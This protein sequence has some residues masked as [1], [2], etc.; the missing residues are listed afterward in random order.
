LPQKSVE[1][2]FFNK[3]LTFCLHNLGQEIDPP[4]LLGMAALAT[5]ESVEDIA[6][7]EAR[8]SVNN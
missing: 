8:K 7:F 4:F 1:I 3:N 5:W 6:V 2:F